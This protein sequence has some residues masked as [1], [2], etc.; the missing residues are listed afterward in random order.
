MDIDAL[1][2]EICRRV[3]E[4]VDAYE[5]QENKCGSSQCADMP[6]LLILT[7]SHGTV[8]HEA[9][10]CPKLSEYYRTECALLKDYDCDMS[11]YEAVIAYTMTNEA[12]G[13]I[14]N[15][16]FDSGYTRLFGQALLSGKK[17]FLPKE[18]VELLGYREMAPAPYYSRLEENLRLLQSSGVVVASNSELASLILTGR[19]ADMRVACDTAAGGLGAAQ[20]VS[21]RE[22]MISK[23]V[24]T[25][26]DVMAA[27]ADK[28]SVI[29]VGEKAILTDLAREYA[30]KR[31]IAI[32]R[33]DSSSSVRG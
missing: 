23:R 9:L 18:E 26:K 5:A 16:I 8:C 33:Q 6:K 15:G 25:E 19:P 12:L 3:Q 24:I 28:A 21:G 14:A 29:V 27:H 22:V 20:Q 2:S 1:V 10:E 4:R 13:K 7:Q 31:Q 17:I 30:N 11:E 32:L